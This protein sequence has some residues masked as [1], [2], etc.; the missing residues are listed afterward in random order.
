[1]IGMI[2]NLDKKVINL[3]LKF[4]RFSFFISLIGIIALYIFVE[5]YID[6]KLYYI[7]I[8]IFRTGILSAVCSFCFGMFFNG[9]NKGLIHK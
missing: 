7:S 2:R 4:E 1:M 5:F 8:I 6:I 9:L 3:I